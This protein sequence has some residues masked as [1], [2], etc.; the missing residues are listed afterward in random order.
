MLYERIGEQRVRLSCLYAAVEE[1]RSVTEQL[2]R[3][4]GYE[5]VSVVGLESA[6]APE[7]FV[8][9]VFAKVSRILYRFAPP[10]GL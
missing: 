5:P 6:R 2:I 3:D 9:E 7:D 8:T 1:A 10:G 4:A